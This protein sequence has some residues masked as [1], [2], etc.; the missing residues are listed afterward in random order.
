MN[1]DFVIFGN[2][3]S[4]YQ[5]VVENNHLTTDSSNI[6]IKVYTDKLDNSPLSRLL[7]L[8]ESTKK[9]MEK[10]LSLALKHQVKL[11]ATDD[12]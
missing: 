9:Q 10:N 3:D 1:K 7:R 8:F 2:T 11:Y 4:Y 6:T 12:N 5:A